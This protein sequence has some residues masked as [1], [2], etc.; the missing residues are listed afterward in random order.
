MLPNLKKRVHRSIHSRD[1]TYIHKTQASRHLGFIEL[2]QR[3]EVI[4]R[5][6]HTTYLEKQAVCLLPCAKTHKRER[7]GEYSI[8]LTP[9]SFCASKLNAC[10]TRYV[11]TGSQLCARRG[12]KGFAKVGV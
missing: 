9:V 3:D 12:V 2:T 10:S 7:D 11:C 6:R 1:N 8:F 5:C 4:E